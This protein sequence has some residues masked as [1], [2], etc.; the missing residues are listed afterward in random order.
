MV[1]PSSGDIG[2]PSADTSLWPHVRERPAAPKKKRPKLQF[3]EL[4]SQESLFVL[5]LLKDT[6]N[7]YNIAT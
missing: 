2:V 1:L 5:R 4:S 7:E 6:F 3:R